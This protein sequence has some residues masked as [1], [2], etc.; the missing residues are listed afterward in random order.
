ME[1]GASFT[2]P[3]CGEEVAVSIKQE[4]EQW[5]INIEKPES[6]GGLK[7]EKESEETEKETTE[8]ET[9]EAEIMSR[10]DQIEEE[11]GEQNEEQISEGESRYG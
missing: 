3:S 11:V 1:F 2:C 4:D 6:K 9:E 7:K 10:M 5:D 8:K